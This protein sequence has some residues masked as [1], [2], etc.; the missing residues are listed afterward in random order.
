MIPSSVELGSAVADSNIF[1]VAFWSAHKQMCGV[2]IYGEREG[3]RGNECV[4]NGRDYDRIGWVNVQRSTREEGGLH[5][6]QAGW[7]RGG[8]DDRD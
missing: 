1:I 8:D 2:D 5:G 6:K 4:K 3:E 7:C